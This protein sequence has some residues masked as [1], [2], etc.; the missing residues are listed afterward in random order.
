MDVSVELEIIIHKKKPHTKNMKEPQKP[1]LFEVAQ[2]VS[3]L[4]T[5]D[6]D[7]LKD[8]QSFEAEAE[9]ASALA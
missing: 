8:R 2:R 7:S 9:L 1:P 6:G 4:Q 5:M 3:M